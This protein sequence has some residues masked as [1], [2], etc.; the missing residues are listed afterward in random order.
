MVDSFT[1]LK[2]LYPTGQPTRPREAGQSLETVV[3]HFAIIE[4]IKTVKHFET[5]V[6]Y[7]ET[8]VKHLET[9]EHFKT[10]VEYLETSTSRPSSIL[11]SLRKSKPLGAFRLPS[12]LALQIIL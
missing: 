2:A 8:V 9:V 10:V 12:T 11:R 5:V 7:L 4:Y 1:I 3:E 6:E